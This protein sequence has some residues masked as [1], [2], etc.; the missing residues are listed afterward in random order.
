MDGKFDENFDFVSVGIFGG[1]VNWYLEF[2][3]DLFRIGKRVDINFIKWD[4]LEKKDKYILS[5]YNIDKKRS[6]EWFISKILGIIML[7]EGCIIFVENFFKLGV[8]KFLDFKNWLI[9]YGMFESDLMLFLLIY[10]F[11]LNF[12]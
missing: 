1:I 2:W 8:I 7:F 5:D 9:F 12:Y 10:V 4:K 3:I 6:L 11:K